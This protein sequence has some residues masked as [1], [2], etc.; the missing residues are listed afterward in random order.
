MTPPKLLVER[1]SKKRVGID[2]HIMLSCVA[3]GYPV[4]TYRSDFIHPR[5]QKNVNKDNR[6][7]YNIPSYD[8][9]RISRF[10]QFPL[11]I[12]RVLFFC[13]ESRTQLC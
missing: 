9:F 12:D 1:Q 6:E 13:K 5:H 2:E 8:E 11:P 7:K 3:Q 10:I 4:P